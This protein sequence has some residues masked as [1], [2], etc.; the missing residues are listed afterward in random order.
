MKQKIIMV[1]VLVILLSV[2]LFPKKEE[3]TYLN[4]SANP[5]HVFEVS[6]VC[7]TFQT[8]KSYIHE[9]TVK[10]VFEDAF[11]V[12]PTCPIDTFN[13]NQVITTNQTIHLTEVS[14]EVPITT[15]VNI[16]KASF[17]T[18]ITV[19]GITETRAASIIIYREQH[20]DFMDL[21]ELIH[22]KYIGVSTL[23]KIKPYLT[24]S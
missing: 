18:L 19:P 10:E 14:H 20:G 5:F 22:V 8:E 3:T 21:D 17:Q 7:G 4:Q 12:I 6:V 2:W 13:L 16:N 23:E 1:V 24:I 11:L 9:T 15:Q